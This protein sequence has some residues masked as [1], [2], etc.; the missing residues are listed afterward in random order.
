MAAVVASHHAGLWQGRPEHSFHVSNINLNNMVPSY[1]APRTSAAQ[2]SSRS[3]QP[4]TSHMEMSMPLF[5]TNP[6]SSSVPYQSGQY[7]FDPAT[8]N[9]YGIQFNTI[10]Y[11]PNASQPVSY[12]SVSEVQTLPTVREARNAFSHDG[13]LMVKP[14]SESSSV[15]NP[16]Y[17]D[18]SHSGELKRS[19]SE[20]TQGTAPNFATDVDTLMKAIQAKQTTSS[21]APEPT[22]VCLSSIDYMTK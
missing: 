8:A 15:A 13:H 19:H 3:Y 21:P 9:P 20:P 12:S 4:T 6:M 22:E 7:S 10:N 14:E 18:V 11:G 2:Q 1:D 17:N 16:M 5:S